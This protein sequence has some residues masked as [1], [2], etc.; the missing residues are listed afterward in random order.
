MKD[1][2]NRNL[3][4]KELDDEQLSAVS[5]GRINARDYDLCACGRGTVYKNGLCKHC[6]D[7]KDN[8]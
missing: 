8:K 4:M 2:G 5:G 7:A 1:T 6:Y 3:T